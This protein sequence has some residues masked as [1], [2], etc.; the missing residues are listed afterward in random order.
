MPKWL[1]WLAYLRSLMLSFRVIAFEKSAETV[2]VL[3]AA[4]AL[5]TVA[6]FFMNSVLSGFA[7]ICVT[8]LLYYGVRRWAFANRFRLIRPGDR[9]EYAKVTQRDEG[10]RQRFETGVVLKRMKQEV[11]ER[12]R[13]FNAELMGMSEWFYLVSADEQMRIVPL[14]WIVSIAFDE[15]IEGS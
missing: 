8:L 1:V 3:W 5:L 4:P 6:V 9:I 13:E 15:N 12:S 2:L 10:Y 7:A 14:E 11:A